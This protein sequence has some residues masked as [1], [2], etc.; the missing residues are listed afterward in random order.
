MMTEIELLEAANT[1]ISF[2]KEYEKTSLYL[3]F[4]NIDEYDHKLDE[5]FPVAFSDSEDYIS[6]TY[7]DMDDIMPLLRPMTQEEL[8]ARQGLIKQVKQREHDKMVN[9]A[10][11]D[12]MLNQLKNEADPARLDHEIIE[13]LYNKQ[14]KASV[15]IDTGYY[16]QGKAVDCAIVMSNIGE[17][18]L[19]R[20]AVIIT[21]DPYKRTF[22][23]VN[24][25][26]LL[27]PEGI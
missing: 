7:S 22:R 16:G 24:Q 14:P 19:G 8:E 6:L 11:H 20:Q 2:Q 18:G 23:I 17:N 3:E 27:L 5:E 13:I 10:R 15:V 25:D 4:G 9:R 26:H 1:S 12:A 21:G